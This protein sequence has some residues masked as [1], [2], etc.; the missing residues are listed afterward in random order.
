MIGRDFLPIF[1]F[2][3]G[4]TQMFEIRRKKSAPVASKKIAL[5]ARPALM[6]GGLNSS[7]AP[8]K[9]TTK[10]TVT[11][12][13]Q[14]VCT[15]VCQWCNGTGY[16]TYLHR[17]CNACEGSGGTFERQLRVDSVTEESII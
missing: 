2:Y 4:G 14:T 16:S 7:P 13:M 6:S 15:S 12:K 8:T 1:I 9:I 3:L 11:K 17:T 10:K 5:S